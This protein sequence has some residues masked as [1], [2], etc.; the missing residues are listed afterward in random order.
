MS[1]LFLSFLAETLASAE[2]G[3]LRLG[4]MFFDSGGDTSAPAYQL[5]I[6]GQQVSWM[7]YVD[8]EGG[9]VRVVG[10]STVVE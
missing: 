10:V 6:L 2:K 7:I 5:Y 8:V 3:A 1:V 4:S 9:V